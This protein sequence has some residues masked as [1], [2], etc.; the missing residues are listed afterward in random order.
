MIFRDDTFDIGL[1][2][3]EIQ[4][5]TDR[6]YMSIIDAECFDEAKV[7]MDIVRVNPNQGESVISTIESIYQTSLTQ[8]VQETLVRI[9]KVT[10]R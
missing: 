2:K 5:Y 6:D 8:K 9:P 7:L 10:S 4:S 3:R 1:D